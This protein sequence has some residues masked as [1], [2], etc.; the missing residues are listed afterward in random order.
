LLV[1][2]GRAILTSVRGVCWGRRK[3]LVSRGTK[4]LKEKNRKTNSPSCRVDGRSLDGG[5]GERLT[6]T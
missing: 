6:G 2:K 4:R 1:G 5:K 3:G